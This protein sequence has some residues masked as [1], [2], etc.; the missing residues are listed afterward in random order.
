MAASVTSLL[1]ARRFGPLFLCQFTG[2]FV[3]NVF[4]VAMATLI[5]YQIV[6]EADRANLLVQA[7]SAVF[8]LPFFMFS[9]TSGQLAD[10]S[11]K[12]RIA[13]WN[14]LSEFLIMVAAAWA[15]RAGSLPGMFA[16][17]FALGFQATVFGPVKYGILPQHLAPDELLGGNALIEGA[18]FLAI[19]FGQILGITLLGSGILDPTPVTIL[20]LA[21]SAL[22]VVAAFAIPSAPPA[23]SGLRID[24]NPVRATLGLLRLAR[25]RREIWLTIQGISWFWALG[26]ILLA[27]IIPLTESVLHGSTRVATFL[28]AT[29][30]VGIALGSAAIA[31]ILQGRPSAQFAPL[32]ALVM[33]LALLG[34]CLAISA[35]DP[36]AGTLGLRAFLSRPSAWPIVVLFFVLALAGGA[37]S[38]PLYTLLQAGTEPSTRARIIAANNIVNALY[39]AAGSVAAGLVM[40]LTGGS[41]LALFLLLGLATLAAAML[42]VSLL[43]DELLKSLLQTLFR[44]LYRVE[45]SGLDHYER[46]GARAVI[47]VNHISFI[48]GALLTAFLP[49]KPSFAINTYIARQWWLRPFLR[50]INAYP[51]DP[52]N[53]LSI[54]TMVR[55]VREGHKLVIFPEGRITVT[56]ALMK[57][58]EGPGMVADRAQADIVPIRIDGAQYTP[59]S[60]LRGKMRLRRFPRITIQVLEPRRFH[61]P[62]GLPPRQRRQVAGQRLYDLMS[63]LIFE[64]CDTGQSLFR[65]LLDARHVHGG[66]HLILEDAGRQPQS[67]NRLVLASR[68]LGRVLASATQ[69]GERVGILLPNVAGTAITF[70]ALQAFGRVPAMLNFTAGLRNMQAACT[71]ADIRLVI[72]SRQFIEQARLEEITTGLA[73]QVRLLWLEDV[74]ESIGPVRRAMG[75][76]TMPLAR[77]LH[78]RET[79]LPDEPAVV[80]FTSGSEGLPKAVVLSHRNLLAN[81]Y[82]LAA[83]VD[84]TPVDIVFNAMPV[85]HS[86]GLTGGLLL[87]LLSGVK[88]F[89]YPSPLHYR[90]VPALVYD[91][92]ATILFGTDT[93]LSGYARMS[94]AYDF[95]AVRYVFAGAEKVRDT[96]RALWVEKFGLRILE[97]YGATEAAPV[98]AVNTPMHYRAGTVGRLLPGIDAQLTPVEGLAEGARLRIRGPNVMMGYYRVEEPGRLQPPPEGWYDTGDIVSIDA[99]GFVTILGRARR[100]AKIGGEMVSLPAVEGMAAEC[101]PDAVHAA[102]SRADARK[103]EQLV[104]VTTQAGATAGDLLAWA[105]RRGIAE[106]MI[107]KNVQ[108][109]EKLPLLGSGKVDYMTLEKT[110]REQGPLI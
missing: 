81:R 104:L 72:T 33:A 53:P 95:Y 32:F 54:K 93:F 98:I 43:P 19:L 71:A 60:R 7:A 75:L 21:T 59:F 61:L 31:R 64:T 91:A 82:Q 34:L 67:Y 97:G 44:L 78:Q 6:L 106:I 11:D 94:H 108:A 86:F 38:V 2:A 15:L 47:V 45:V 105:R 4:R 110:V 37:Y 88:T 42:I 24:L 27:Q 69:R 65:A 102:V 62:T 63:L 55:A 73:G 80:L 68:V 103:G 107:P 92:N 77:W 10:A 13:R 40:T 100:F 109:W 50:L 85:F 56:G 28:L 5:V 18:T 49:G 12:A 36:T 46:A 17:L 52:T 101:W 90:I 76:A 16:V 8:I 22:G 23:T 79:V 89:L 70:F 66:R 41:F 20:C 9:A 1:K 48:D 30:S 83:R 57:V 25:D 96:T 74:R 29:F 87:P 14:K 35:Y 99:A 39:M 84:F 58:F 26:I 3:D 51:V